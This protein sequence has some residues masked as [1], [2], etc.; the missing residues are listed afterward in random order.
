FATAIQDLAD[1]LTGIADIP[2]QQS[3]FETATA[4][5]RFCASVDIQVGINVISQGQAFAGTKLRALAE[6]AGMAIDENG[7]FVRRDD[8]D[9]VLYALL[10]QDTAG[11]S[12][13]TMRS[14]STHGIT[15]LLDVPCV[16]HGERV[17]G[18]MIDLAQRF[19]DVLPGTLVDDNR[20]PLTEKALEPVSRQ[21][22]HYQ[23][24]LAEKQLPAGSRLAQR[25]FS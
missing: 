20:R 13:E 8:D 9:N 10:N 22:A 1:Q 3:A 7:R 14:M 18:Q 21:I 11:F 5:D 15:F 25:L 6:A 19:A 24:L 12:A 4:L 17:F 2:S 23:T 16:A